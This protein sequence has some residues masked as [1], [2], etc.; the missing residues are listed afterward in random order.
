MDETAGSP[1]PD[2]IYVL[3]H[4]AAHILGAAV[5]E[6]YPD[7]RYADGPP[8]EDPPGFYYD[9]ELSHRITEDDLPAIEA[10]MLKII[11]ANPGFEQ[12]VIPRADAIRLF[13]ERNQKFKV[14]ILENDITADEVSV[15]RTGE[16]LDLCRGPHLDSAIQIGAVKLLKLGGAYWRKDEKNAQ[17]QRV[18]GTAWPTT[19]ELEQYLSDLAEAEKR[20]HKR[21]G[22]DLKLFA[23]DDRAGLGN[24]IWLP[25]GATVRREIE[26]WVVD[27]E[28]A[29]GYQHV[30]TPHL[31]KLDLYRQ[32]GHYPL[33]EDSMFP[34]MHLESGE[35][36]EL[37]P[38]NCPHHI[39]VYQQDLRSYRDLPLR[40]AEVGQNYRYEKS[41]ELMGMIRVRSFALN[42]AH[43]F[44]TAAS[45]QDEIVAAV[46]LA[47][48][49]MRTLGVKMNRYRLSIRDEVKAKWVGSDEQWSHAQNALIAALDQVGEPYDVGTGE[50]AFYGPKIDFQIRDLQRREFTNSTVQVDFQ[51]PER[52]DLEYVAEDGT[53]QRP[54]MIHRGA[55]G[56]ME[57]IIAYLIELYG[58]AFPTWLAPVQV[59]LVPVTDAQLEYARGVAATLRSLRL[60][61]EV[62]ERSE[63][64]GRKVRDA[65]VRKVPY[66]AV[67][68][69]REMEGGTVAVRGRGA[70]QTVESV[71][72]FAAR[73]GR[74]VAT[75]AT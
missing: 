37:R 55:V 3:R 7:A 53:R 4:S 5:L 49:F 21:L 22:R 57:R 20:D 39:M 8:V 32:S 14:D 48:Y 71:D 45:L 29:R 30:V 73:V 67:I 26:R 54:I 34:P 65:E 23:L 2:P 38:M 66:I 64:M 44:C 72:D 68:G 24:V 19:T 51:L 59:V 36:L 40:I 17:L 25:N 56:A 1:T 31:A 9:F 43:I 70:E 13:A 69:G 61:V 15:Y 58:G 35:E 52:F 10:R 16:F 47:Q 62:D 60:R 75:R 33:Y 28:L 11:A 42:D 50:A 41:G 27:E 6:L 63:R 74:E 46:E 18:Y 12:Q